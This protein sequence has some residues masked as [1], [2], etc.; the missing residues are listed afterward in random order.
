ML[1]LYGEADCL[2]ACS[3]GEAS[4]L[5]PREAMSTGIPAIVTDWG[6]LQE[7]A[8]PDCN[9]VLE[10]DG[11]ESALGP[12][13]PITA[14]GGSSI[15][16]LATPSVEHLRTLMRAAYEDR[17]ATRAKGQRAAAWMRSD[18][19]YTTCAQKWVEAITRLVEPG[20]ANGNGRA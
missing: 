9:F 1:W 6:G 19:T 3:R 14:S 11:E 10:I 15:G 5:T 8:N 16:R 2:V 20:Q 17:A 18:W 4:G 13:Y 12:I 7:I